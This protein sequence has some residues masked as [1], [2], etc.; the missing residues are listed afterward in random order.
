MPRSRLHLD[1]DSS[2]KAL[3]TTLVERGH[4]ATRTPNDWMPEGASDEAQLLGATAEGRCIL[5][6]N[7]RHF[8]ILAVRFP[9][10]GGIILAEQRGWSLPELIEALD[11]LLSETSAEDWVGQVRWLNQCRKGRT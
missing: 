2:I 9:N 1:A 5:T 11:R 7:I 3:H 4:D 6:F 10:H 8:L